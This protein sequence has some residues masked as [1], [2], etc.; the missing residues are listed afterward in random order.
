MAD[1]NSAFEFILS[2]QGLNPYLVEDKSDSKKYIM[3]SECFFDEGLKKLSLSIGNINNKTCSHCNSK[4]GA[5][6]AKLHLRKLCYS[7]FVQGTIEK[8]KYGGCPLIQFNEQ[9]YGKS[10]VN[11]SSWLKNDLKL[12]EE[13]G[14]IGIFYYGPRLWM[15]GEISPL[16]KLQMTKHRD[17]IINQIL[18][19]YPRNILNSEH[20]FY[21]LRV[22]PKIP[23][24]FTEYD[25]PPDACLGKNRFDTKDS[26]MLYGSPDLDLC[27]HECRV[28]AE[29][30]VYVSKLSPIRP[31]KIL[32][33]C[34]LIDEDK[35]T[36]FESL[37]LAIHFLFLA[38]KNSYKICKRIAL[39]AKEY[40]FDGIIYPSY[41]SNTRTGTVPFETVYGMSIRKVPDLRSFAESKSIPNLVIFG[42]P[43]KEGK[44]KVDCINKLIIKKVH[45]ETSFGPAFH[46]PYEI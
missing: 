19:K 30:N 3:C 14:E 16:K 36:E 38:S 45:Y 1:F 9:F 15:L 35:V 12:I 6:L 2:Q 46:E 13:H 27:I 44:I 40:G 23:H 4:T 20:F 18:E 17:K 25:S 11:V 43:I 34:A 29:D 41:F 10:E 37:D 21:R 33:L 28:T 8:F 31:L 24:A 5:K 7:F 42:R 26:P 39:K 32:N 22:N